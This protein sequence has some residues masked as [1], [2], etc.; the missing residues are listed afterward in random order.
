MVDNKKIMGRPTKLNDDMQRKLV[1]LIMVGNYIETAV[2]CVGLNKTTF[3]EWLKRGRAERDRVEK[4]YKAKV[5][6]SEEKY[7]NF[8]NAIEKAIAESEARDV[9]RISQAGDVNWQALAWRLERRFPDKWGRKP[10]YSE[11]EKERMK[12]ENEKVKIEME[13]LRKEIDTKNIFD[14]LTVEE[15]RQL[16][17]LEK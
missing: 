6:K 2:E 13:K 8:T 16:I 4:N 11:L 12:L 7:V 14:E 9:A 15:L 3:Y 1:A 5:R 17:S 10:V